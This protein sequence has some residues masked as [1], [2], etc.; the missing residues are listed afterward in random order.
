MIINDPRVRASIVG[1]AGAVVGAIASQVLAGTP[2][3][4]GSTVAFGGL[5]GL[6]MGAALTVM[7]VLG[8]ESTKRVKRA[9][10]IGAI[11]GLLGGVLGAASGQV[12]YSVIS[13]AGSS[14]AGGSVFSA[15]MQK[16]LDAAGAKSGEI[17]IGLIWENS[18]DLDLH[19]V[20]PNGERIYFGHP[21]SRSDGELDVDRNAGCTQ[22][23]TDKPVEHVVWPPGRA[24]KGAY[25]I[26][27]HHFANCGTKDPTPFTVELVTG[28]KR[29]TFSGSVSDGDDAAPV[30]SFRWPD[31][32]ASGTNSLAT[33]SLARS[34]AR[35]LG[36]IIFG[37]LM[38]VAQGVARRSTQTLRN[39]G[40]GGAIG[41]GLGAA[42]FLF[43]ATVAAS[44]GVG[45]TFARL[46]GMAILGACV[47]LCMVLVERALSAALAIR[48]GKYEGREIFLDKPLIRIG[49]DDSLELFLGGDTQIAAHHA[50]IRR[51]GDGFSIES[52][53]A[54][55]SVNG[56]STRTQQL[57]DGDTLRLGNT[58]MVFRDR[59]SLVRSDRGQ[60]VQERQ[61]GSP[62]VPGKLPPPPP[63]PPPPRRRPSD[64]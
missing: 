55:V 10:L 33:G 19:V 30:H 1:G 21:I 12:A 15:A 6:C 20:E 40:L 39:A 44:A 32:A 9:L 24:P 62:S 37:G 18:N 34:L 28:G 45:D 36:W 31:S 64:R 49:R 2:N 42:G 3:S 29:T 50:N 41:G 60:S 46:L 35:I 52:V 47:G 14:P 16:R 13:R 48:S 22:N 63:P 38:G 51:D 27:V 25:Q 43:V 4:I 17:E 59:L 53:D 26:L 57:R 56:S 61:S 11:A 7:P 54:S 23:V 8:I 58:R 5:V